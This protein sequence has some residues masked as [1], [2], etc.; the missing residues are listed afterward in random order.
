MKMK[1]D[2][3]REIGEADKRIRKL[4][5][6]RTQFMARRNSLNIDQVNEARRI[7][8]E[9]EEIAARIV[10]FKDQ[11]KR[12]EQQVA[13]WK[14]N[15][16]QAAPLVQQGTAAYD[17]GRSI[18]ES[19]AKHQQ[20][21]TELLSKLDEENAIMS[22]VEGQFRDSTGEGMGL[23][24]PIQCYIGMAFAAPNV[25][26]IQG[27][28]A[29]KFVSESELQEQ[30]AKE[31]AEKKRLTDQCV[32]KAEQAAPICTRCGRETHLDRSMTPMGRGDGA[33]WYFACKCGNSETKF[34]PGTRPPGR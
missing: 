24:F 33:S 17:R 18:V 27:Y 9:L 22:T 7:D 11:K 14:S 10:F 23:P 34:I 19:I 8:Q 28:D 21:V 26:R 5:E 1:A 13:E 12:H 20:E 16:A 29:W 25:P 32:K 15:A 3:L 2:S 30:K 6:Q 4:E 31:D